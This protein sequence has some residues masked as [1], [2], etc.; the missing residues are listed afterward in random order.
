MSAASSL[1]SRGDGASDFDRR[2]IRIVVLG[3]LHTYTL[4]VRPWELLGKTLA[5]QMNLWLNR[6]RKFDRSLIAPTIARAVECRPDLVLMSG[7]LTTTSRPREFASI[8]KDLAPLLDAAPAVIIPGNHDRYTFTAQRSQRMERAF[9]PHVPD[10]FPYTRNLIGRWK[11]LGVDA[12]TPRLVDSC[13]RFGTRQL[14]E[15]RAMLQSVGSDDGVIVLTHYPIGKPPQLPPMKPG[16]RLLDERAWR[17][18][19]NSCP[20]RVISI[21]GHVHVPWLWRPDMGVLLPKSPQTTSPVRL[22]D[23]NAGAPAHVDDIATHDAG[24]EQLEKGGGRRAMGWPRGQGFWEIELPADPAHE[25]ALTHH[26]MDGGEAP[27]GFEPSASEVRSEVKSE[28]WISRTVR[29]AL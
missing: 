22:L 17:E 10:S 18:T 9:R 25:I 2:T 3:D 12:S 5:G 15:S 28:S 7:D 20:G 1:A 16:H 8:A 4:W 21:H 19:L 11:L 26:V 13:G 14:Q 6:R 27:I 24:A 29:V 23:I